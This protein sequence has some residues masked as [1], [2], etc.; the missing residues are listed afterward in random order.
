MFQRSIRFIFGKED[1]M[2][3][4]ATLELW[5]S[6][7]NDIQ[8]GPTGLHAKIR[9]DTG[10]ARDGL[11]RII[12]NPKFDRGLPGGEDTVSI[13]A[14]E[15]GHFIS[16]VFHSPTSEL[17]MQGILEP[18]EQLAWTLAKKMGVRINPATV[19]ESMRSYNGR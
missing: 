13:V 9:R 12:I 16:S 18:D 15:M 2:K 17:S 8:N 6:E 7:D 4:L 11:Y 1:S 5:Q 10:E 3:K 14:H 19:A